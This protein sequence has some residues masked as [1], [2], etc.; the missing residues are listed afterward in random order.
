MPETLDEEK[1]KPIWSMV[2][3]LSLHM[4]HD[5]MEAEDAAQSVMERVVMKSH[6][7]K[8]DAQFSTWV[9]RLAYNH[10]IDRIRKQNREK[11]SFELFE[12][13]VRNFTPYRNELGLN[14]EEEKIFAEELKVGCT[15]AMLQCLDSENRFI[16]I[17]KTIFGF[18]GSKGAEICGIS[19]ENFRKRYS[20]T[21]EK[22]RNFL[23]GNCSHINPEAFCSCRKRLHIAVE[24]GRINPDKMLYVCEDRKVRDLILE[25]NQIDKIAELFRSNP[26][27]D[28]TDKLVSSLKSGYRILQ[29]TP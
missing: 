6:E 19:P 27:F 2:F 13:D 28:R 18:T 1:L 11:I 16:Y 17:L 20:R 4:L 22:I 29:E 8:G 7:F 3:N 25:M 9:Y 14:R 23:D 24:R 26:Y 12:K 15:L 10:L 5:H 21:K